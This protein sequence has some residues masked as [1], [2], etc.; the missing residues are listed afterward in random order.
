M[1]RRLYI[2]CQQTDG[3]SKSSHR[4]ADVTVVLFQN[5]AVEILGMNAHCQRHVPTVQPGAAAG[6]GPMKFGA[7][8]TAPP[9]ADLQTYTQY[10]AI[11]RTQLACA[12]EV[13]DSLLDCAKK[14][15]AADRTSQQAQ[16]PASS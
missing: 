9:V 4:H 11:V 6:S 10:Q 15:Q 16:Q 7:S 13:H 8:V 5:L 14:I 2:I 3:Q 1:I 12:K